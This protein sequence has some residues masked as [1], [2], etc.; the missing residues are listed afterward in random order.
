MTETCPTCLDNRAALAERQKQVAELQAEVRQ[1]RLS[2]G[3]GRDESLDDAAQRVFHSRP[4]VQESTLNLLTKANA[5]LLAENESLQTDLAALKGK[6]KRAYGAKN[7]QR[8]LQGHTKD[9]ND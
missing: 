5:R 4:V 6:V 7:L 8:L 3:A 2:L 1:A 9:P